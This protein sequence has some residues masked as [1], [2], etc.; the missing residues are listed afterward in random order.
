M[1][2]CPRILI[3]L[4]LCTL[5]P[6]SAFAAVGLQ[7]GY[8][9]DYDWAKEQE[10]VNETQQ[11]PDLSTGAL[12]E[13]QQEKELWDSRKER[14]QDFWVDMMNYRK[15]VQDFREGHKERKQKRA[16]K[17]IDCREDVRRANRDT[18]NPITLHCFRAVLTTDL[19]ILRKQKQYVEGIAG[20]REEYRSAALFH[21]E[22]LMDAIS[23]IIQAIDAGVYSDKDG[24]ADAKKNLGE[25]YRTHHRLAMTHMRIDRSITWLIHLM[26]RLKTIEEKL[27]PAEEVV[28]K[29]DEAIACLEVKQSALEELLPMEDNEALI[30]A[31]RQVQSEVKI[32]TDKALEAHGLYTENEQ[33]ETE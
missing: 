19:E 16:Q 24:V 18:V 4:A 3:V 21:I 22:N 8:D 31:F 17:R 10:P 29:M 26:V 30:V 9:V 1:T 23:T 5:S 14:V 12:L 20:L 15:T 2:P 32:C 6:T 7:P 25:A 28:A 11:E 27:D 33:E 13:M